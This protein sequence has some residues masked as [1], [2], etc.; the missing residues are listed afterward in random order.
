MPQLEGANMLT[1]L[2][3]KRTYIVSIVFGIC[4]VLLQLDQDAVINLAPVVEM[5]INLIMIIMI[6]LVPVFLRVA[7]EKMRTNRY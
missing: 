6:P 1:A 4:A 2:V 3:G 5:V 7:V